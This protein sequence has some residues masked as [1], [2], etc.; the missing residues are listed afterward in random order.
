[1]TIFHLQFFVL[2]FTIF[3]IKI[4]A[5]IDNSVFFIFIGKNQ[6]DTKK[7]FPGDDFRRLKLSQYYDDHKPSVVYI[8]GWQGKIER[9]ASQG[10]IDAYL[11]R[12]DH[13]II[14]LDWSQQAKKLNYMK[15]AREMNEVRIERILRIWCQNKFEKFLDFF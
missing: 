4:A 13:N 9:R 14:F 10:V 15:T 8:H 7:M 2:I 3:V 11:I 1:M 12:G 6:T 5:N